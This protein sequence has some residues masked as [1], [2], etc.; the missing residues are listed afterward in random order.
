LSALPQLIPISA[1]RQRQAEILA[2]L[3]RGPVL[4][5]QRSQA[6]A[7]LVSPDEWNATMERLDDLEDTVAALRTEL[8]LSSGDDELVD[9]D[10]TEA[11]VVPDQNR[12]VRQA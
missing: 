9:W 12:Q 3:S 10:D 4:L 6:A 1:I 2:M 8:A 5:V 7:V 11:E